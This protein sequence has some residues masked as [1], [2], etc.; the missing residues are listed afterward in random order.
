[1]SCWGVGGKIKRVEERKTN[2]QEREKLL[3]PFIYGNGGTGSNG[4]KST[5]APES[6]SK[7]GIRER[8]MLLI[9]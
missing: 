9:Q 8:T 3:I 6:Q 4:K 7:E 1:M 5:R 2:L